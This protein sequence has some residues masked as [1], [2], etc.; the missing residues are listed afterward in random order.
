[1]FALRAAIYLSFMGPHGLRDVAEHCVRK[2]HYT[3]EQILSDGRFERKFP[4]STF[5][6]FVVRDTA[7]DVPQLIDEGLNDGVLAGVHLGRWYPELEDCML[8][9]VTEKRTRADIERLVGSLTGSKQIATE[10]SPAH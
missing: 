7:G 1:L 10:P 9:S 5:K 2:A 3:A 8:V 4:H 6:E